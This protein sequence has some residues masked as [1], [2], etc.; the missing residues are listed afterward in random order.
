MIRFYWEGL[1]RVAAAH[2]KLEV[3]NEKKSPNPKKSRGKVSDVA[4]TAMFQKRPGMSIARAI[5]QGKER[6]DFRRLI[7]H[8]KVKGLPER[9]S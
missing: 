8:L 9:K 5:E 1:T 4:T 7:S 2:Y 6:Y 3:V